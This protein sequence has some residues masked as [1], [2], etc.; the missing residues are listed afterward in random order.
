[1][2]IAD[3]LESMAETAGI[4]GGFE[5]LL[6]Q[7]DDVAGPSTKTCTSTGSTRWSNAPNSHG[8]AN[9]LVI[10]RQFGTVW[11]MCVTIPPGITPD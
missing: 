1:M 2:H 9:S 8:S 10:K 6:A 4:G 7:H 5:L 11:V 3:V